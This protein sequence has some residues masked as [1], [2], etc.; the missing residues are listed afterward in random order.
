MPEEHISD[1]MLPF[2]LL[3]DKYRPSNGKLHIADV[4]HEERENLR[5]DA[6]RA[7]RESGLPCFWYAIHVAGLHNF[8]LT[9]ESA[10]KEA[11][12]A[13]VGANGRIRGRS[14]RSS[15][16]S[17]HVELFL[18]LYGHLIAFLNERNR[19]S[20]YI[21]IRMDQID[22]PIVKKFEA[23]AK[24]LL[25]MQPRVSESAA[26]D[27][28]TKTVLKRRISIET[29]LPPELEIEVSVQ[30]LTMNPV[31][32]AD[33]LVLAADVLANSLNYH[34]I[35]RSRNE[36]CRPLNTAEAIAEHPLA[37]S[38]AAFYHWGSGDLIGDGIYKHPK[39]PKQP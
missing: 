19:R 1:R 6:Y 26:F 24:R 12:E 37:G 33:G 13:A 3:A 31:R 8:Y 30:G 2:N 39:A 17:M 20:V 11:K 23:V 14:P 34:F 38:L 32:K 25:N 36:P 18:G 27:T 4:A 22:S 29:D 10:R 21:E 5:N 16:P 7:I 9:R 15:P 35:N 28:V